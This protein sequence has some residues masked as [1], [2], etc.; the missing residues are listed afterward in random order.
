MPARLE[1]FKAL[2]GD[3]EDRFAEIPL[4]VEPRDQPDFFEAATRQRSERDDHGEHF[5]RQQLAELIET[6]GTRSSGHAA[7]PARR[8]FRR[9]RYSPCNISRSAPSANSVQAGFGIGLIDLPSSR[10]RSRPNPGLRKATSLRT[11]GRAN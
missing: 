5:V 8:M 2:L 1:T 3:S 11:F 9:A 7:V 10:G 6:D 4:S